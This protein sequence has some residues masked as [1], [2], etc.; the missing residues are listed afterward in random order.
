MISTPQFH[1]TKLKFIQ[2]SI[3]TESQILAVIVTEGNVVKNKIIRL[4]HGLDQKTILELNI[5]LNS[6]LNGLTIEQINLGQLRS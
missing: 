1:R 2:L 6:A 5:L 3:V 4:E